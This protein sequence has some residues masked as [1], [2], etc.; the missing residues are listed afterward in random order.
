MGIMGVAGLGI[1]MMSNKIN[2]FNSIHCYNFSSSG[3]KNVI[4]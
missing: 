1:V 3:K 2:Y 4:G